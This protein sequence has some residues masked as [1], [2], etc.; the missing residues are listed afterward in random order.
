MQT[1]KKSSIMEM[2]KGIF[3]MP[4]LEL[5]QLSTVSK[6]IFNYI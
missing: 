3:D 1:Y 4:Q 2:Q 6:N 5:W